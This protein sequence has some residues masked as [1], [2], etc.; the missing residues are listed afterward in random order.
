MQPQRAA[1]AAVVTAPMLASVVGYVD[2]SGLM[3]S[4]NKVIAQRVLHVDRP[5]ETLCSLREDDVVPDMRDFMNTPVTPES[6]DNFLDYA[7]LTLQA[8]K[9][10][11]GCGGGN[12][13]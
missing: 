13:E 7:R 4:A 11:N 12:F 8:W 2:R 6:H 1:A 9:Q 3:E 5:L 10:T